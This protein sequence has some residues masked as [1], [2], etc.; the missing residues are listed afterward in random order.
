[1]ELNN[2]HYNLFTIVANGYYEALFSSYDW[3]KKPLWLW[4]ENVV[5]LGNRTYPIN[6]I[7][8]VSIFAGFLK[9]WSVACQKHILIRVKG[10]FHLS[11]EL[12]RCV[13]LS[14]ASSTKSNKSYHTVKPIRHQNK[15]KL[16]L[17]KHGHE[18]RF[19]VILFT[20]GNL[21]KIIERGNILALC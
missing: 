4:R 9:I 8:D 21:I 19:G 11:L 13:K 15:T 3:G 17:V 16:Y 20:W 10:D 12:T 7:I 18:E 2:L 6:L 14:I 5:F 1:M